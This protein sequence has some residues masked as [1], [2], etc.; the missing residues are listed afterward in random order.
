M[1]TT[2]ENWIS[3]LIWTVFT[4]IVTTGNLVFLITRQERTVYGED[5][6][7]RKL[8]KPAYTAPEWLFKIIWPI[9]YGLVTAS[10]WVL[11]KAGTNDEAL[12]HTSLGLYCAQMV[13]SGGWV[14]LFFLLHFPEL[15]A[16][17]L[18]FLWI[19]VIIKSVI[20]GVQKLWISLGLFIPFVI[21]VTYS[22]YLN[23]GIVLLN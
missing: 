16:I 12:Y 20:L 5:K 9:M 17:D 23:I 8:K 19:I 13:L 4:V 14:V 22:M 6:W 10:N 3:A 2:E 1:T 18:S 7:Y 11:W 15:A 21:W